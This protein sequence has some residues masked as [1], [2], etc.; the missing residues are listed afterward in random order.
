VSV[1]LGYV[2]LG[3]ERRGMVCCPHMGINLQMETPVVGMSTWCIP[4]PF[5]VFCSLLG[6]VEPEGA[7]ASQPLW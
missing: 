3:L 4:I 6:R 1:D 5:A 2:K 7:Q